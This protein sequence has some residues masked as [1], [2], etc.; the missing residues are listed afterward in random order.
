MRAFLGGIDAGVISVAVL[1][2]MTACGGGDESREIVTQPVRHLEMANAL[3]GG[4]LAVAAP[5]Y[6]QRMAAEL[7][8]GLSADDS[9]E[10]L[11][12]AEG[13]PDG[14]RHARL[15]QTHGGVVVFGSEVVV[16][17][18]ETTFVGF[19]GFL[20]RHLDGFDIG[21]QL[22]ADEAMAIA[23]AEATGEHSRE[24]SR[25]VILPGRDGQGAELAWHLEFLAEGVTSVHMW[26]YFIDARDGAV[27]RKFDAVMTEATEQASGQGGNAIFA[28]QWTA[29]LDVVG[30]G[31]EYEMDTDRLKVTDNNT[32]DPAKGPIDAMP[33]PL[34]NDAQG[35]GEITLKMMRE[36][37]GHDSIDSS[38]KVVEQRVHDPA[39]GGACWFDDSVHYSDTG[40]Y[41]YPSQGSIDIVGHEINH[42][43]T[44]FHSNLTYDSGQQ[45]AGLNEAFSSVAGIIVRHYQLGD[46]AGFQL[47]REVLNGGGFVEDLC[48]PTFRGDYI[49]DANDW[50][51]DVEV[52]GAGAPAGR[53][54]CLAVGR[55]KAIGGGSTT[56]AVRE[57]GRIWYQA[58]ASYWTSSATFITS[59]QGTI[60]AAQ[61]LGFSSEVVQALRDSWAD[62][63]A[64]CAGPGSFVC[65]NDDSCDTDEGETCASCPDDCGSCSEDC[66]FWK[67]AKCKVGIGD[68]SRCDVTPGCGDGTCSDDESDET[69]GQDC[70][71]AATDGECFIA[72]FGCYCDAEC[73]GWG[74]C[75]ADLAN[76]CQ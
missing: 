18:D 46:A 56:Y 76:E 50:T 64:E 1:M 27:R 47:A 49:G 71:C 23:Q 36:W 9:F 51:A 37:M 20:T 32:G 6:L 42:G 72:P 66:S 15:Q 67:K 22:S 73:L 38:G 55:Y 75:C 25:L 11:S 61:S 10:I 62:V 13:G 60:D 69:C 41:D 4:E 19:N 57:M 5:D 53:A 45:S 48:N 44:Q 16:H 54:F 8:L 31:G 26:N 43:F 58:N 17:A 63:G 7:D 52:H 34:A 21:A 28:K 59:C 24:S 29:E 68:C 70:G 65:D 30:D 39:C 12:L 3:A 74:D 33:D 40:G 14:L 35:Y 2:A